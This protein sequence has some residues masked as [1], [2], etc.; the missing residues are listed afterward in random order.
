VS[1][2]VGGEFGLAHLKGEG[3]PMHPD[4]MMQGWLPTDE[5]YQ[6]QLNAYNDHYG[7]KTDKE[8][9]DVDPK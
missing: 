9:T 2:V 7:F 1:G 8:G 4:D 3:A 5:H 6:R